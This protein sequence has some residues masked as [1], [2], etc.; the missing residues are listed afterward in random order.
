MK[1]IAIS[2]S[3]YIPWK[4]YFDLINMVDEFVL[5]D[6]MQYTK[7]DWRNRNKIKTPQGLK[8]LSIP[9]DVKG[10]YFQKINETI[11]ADPKWSLIHWKTI[12]QCYSKAPFFSEYKDIFEDFYMNNKEECLSLINAQLIK[13]INS[14]LGINTKVTW[15][16]DYELLDGQTEKLLGICKQ[17]DANLYF[18]GPAAKCYFDEALAE[19]MG[20]QVKWVDYSGYPEYHQLNPPFEHGVSILDLIFNEGPEAINFMKS[21]K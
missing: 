12:K 19:K 8:W 11:V 13:T 10:K 1:K 21:F 17:A 6:D 9:V 14:I 15:S 18:S 4:G 2:Q 5:Y 20:I 7:R 3:N 16:S